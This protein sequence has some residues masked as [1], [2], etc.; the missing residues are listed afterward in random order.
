M[1]DQKTVEVLVPGSTVWV[2]TT[3]VTR[4]GLSAQLAQILK[5]TLQALESPSAA[6]I[7]GD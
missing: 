4:F 3:H 6:V 5:N 1:S 7:V 2:V